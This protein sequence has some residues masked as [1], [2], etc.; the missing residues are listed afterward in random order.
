[1]AS[2]TFCGRAS[3]FRHLCFRL[4]KTEAIV[5]ALS[6]LKRIGDPALS[7]SADRVNDRIAAAMPAPLRRAL[8]TGALHAWGATMPT[9]EGVD[10]ADIRAA[11]RDERKLAI[12]YRDEQGRPSERT[13]RPAALVYYS[14][15]SLVVAWCELREGLRNFRTDRI[16]AVEA[17]DDFFRGQG[18]RLRKL[19]TDGW[20]HRPT[21]A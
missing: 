14:A 1:M 6:L 3:T 19:W 10:L 9:P 7:A 21:A 8:T 20:T 4:R 16:V 2:A 13:I 12:R 11:I 18:D 15:H 5:L 17:T